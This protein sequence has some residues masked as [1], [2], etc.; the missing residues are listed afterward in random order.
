[1]SNRLDIEAV[2]AAA[3]RSR[4]D[5]GLLD[6]YF[7]FALIWIG[8]W[9]ILVEDLA[10]FAG[11]IPAVAVVPFVAARTRFLEERAGHVRFSERRRAS[12]RRRLALFA[13]LGVLVL[14]AALVGAIVAAD[15]G[16]SGVGDAI[17]P[18]LIAGIIALPVLGIAA[19]TGVG[20]F[21]VYGA[22]L[23]AGAVVAAATD[24]NP[25]VP[26]LAAG[27]V[28]LVWGLVLVLRFVRSHPRT[29][30]ATA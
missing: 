24:A 14:A 18:G 7:G 23:L 29:T 8:A 22:V 30:E 28:G 17:G 15:G 1:M 11:I 12:E 20:R 27:I 19:I 10:G 3:Y 26:V 9:W 4:F 6:C 16:V 25:G 5:D 2:E 13:A 21:L